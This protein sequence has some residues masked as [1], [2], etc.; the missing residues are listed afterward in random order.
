MWNRQHHF[1]E[2]NKIG[3][4]ILS[5][6]KTFKTTVIKVLCFWFKDDI[7]AM[8]YN[9]Q[10]NCWPIDF[11]KNSKIIKNGIDNLFNQWCCSNYYPSI[12]TD[13]LQN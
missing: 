5:D 11:Y 13:K 3:G 10:K 6:F 2:R 4:I 12:H 8:K 7:Q 1:K 9:I